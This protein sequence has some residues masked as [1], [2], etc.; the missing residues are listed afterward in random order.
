MKAN[1]D[2]IIKITSRLLLIFTHYGAD[3]VKHSHQF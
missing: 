2:S 3:H 1:F